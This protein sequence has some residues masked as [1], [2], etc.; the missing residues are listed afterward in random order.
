MIVLG[1]CMSIMRNSPGRTTAQNGE[2]VTITLESDNVYMPCG[3]TPET[4]DELIKWGGITPDRDEVRRI[5]ATTD[6]VLLN[7]RTA[8]K[9]LD[10]GPSKSKIRVEST[11]TECW[12]VT[13]ALRR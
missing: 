3:S 9:V 1:Y 2:S 8:V 12:V 10:R 6:S 13:E 4:L 7:N 5:V 11:G